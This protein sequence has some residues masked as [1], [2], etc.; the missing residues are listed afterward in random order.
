[1]NN[2]IQTVYDNSLNHLQKKNLSYLN[3]LWRAGGF[4][5]RLMKCQATL[6]IHAFVP[7]LFAHSTSSALEKLVHDM[8]E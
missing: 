1:M 7:G 4:L 2:S 6:T 8:K 3:H 5:L